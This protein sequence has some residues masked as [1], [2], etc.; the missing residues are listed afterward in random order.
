MEDVNDPSFGRDDVLVKILR[1]GICGT[2][3]HIYSWDPWAQENVPIPL[4]VGHEF[5]GHVVELGADVSDLELGDIVSGEGHL[6][7]GRCRNCM[8]GRRVQCAVDPC[9]RGQPSRCFRRAHCHAGYER[10][11]APGRD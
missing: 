3:L 2:D 4:V 8:A 7:C 5:V 11:E 10:L 1:T 9:H 6:V